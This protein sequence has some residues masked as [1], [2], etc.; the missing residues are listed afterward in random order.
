MSFIILLV[1]KLLYKLIKAL[2]CIITFLL[3]AN[4]YYKHILCYIYTNSHYLYNNLMRLVI[5]VTKPIR[6]RPNNLLEIRNFKW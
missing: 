1:E 6:T 4:T 3:I 5:S 2:D